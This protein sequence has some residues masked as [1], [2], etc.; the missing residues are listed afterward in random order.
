MFTGN[1]PVKVV[2]S[3]KDDY[4]IYEV[5]VLRKANK[6]N[7][8]R[9]SRLSM[10]ISISYKNGLFILIRLMDL[11]LPNKISPAGIVNEWVSI[12]LN[13]HHTIIPRPFKIGWTDIT[14]VDFKI[15]EI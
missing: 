6:S 3:C 1:I 2:A 8:I 14:M 9:D 15:L 13:P 4:C 5:G 12:P 7:A 11:L 10:S